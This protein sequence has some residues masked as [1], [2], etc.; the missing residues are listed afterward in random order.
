MSNV[1]LFDQ[2]EW[3]L[4]NNHWDVVSTED[5]IRRATL[6][7]KLE[8]LTRKVLSA[9][10]SPHFVTRLGYLLWQ[11]N[12]LGNNKDVDLTVLELSYDQLNKDVMGVFPPGSS[13][14]LEDEDD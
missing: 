4:R 6:C 12:D 11:A 3:F 9:S 14:E 13:D 8:E 1:S 5:R 7:V 10:F 2:V